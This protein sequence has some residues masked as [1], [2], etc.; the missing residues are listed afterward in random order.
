MAP[1]ASPWPGRLTREV[2][3]PVVP[4]MAKAFRFPVAA[5][6]A[7]RAVPAGLA[8]RAVGWA[9]ADKVPTGVKSPVVALNAMAWIRAFRS[10]AA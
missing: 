2:S 8:A 1:G 6:V 9:P 5:S 3:A 10:S 4:L 7:Y